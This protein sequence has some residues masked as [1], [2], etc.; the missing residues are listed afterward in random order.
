[1]TF[2]TQ[3]ITVAFIG[4]KEKLESLHP[5]LVDLDDFPVYVKRYDLVV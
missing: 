2:L 3:L 1:M 5:V 4:G